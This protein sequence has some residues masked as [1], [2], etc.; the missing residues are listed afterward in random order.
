MNIKGL[1]AFARIISSGTLNAA[2]K[3]L[4]IS[5]SALSRQQTWMQSSGI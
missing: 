5:G 1:R 3:S 2:A 4:N